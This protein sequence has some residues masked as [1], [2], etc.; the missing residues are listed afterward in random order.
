MEVVSEI[1]DPDNPEA[2]EKLAKAISI[3]TLTRKLNLTKDLVAMG[4]CLSDIAYTNSEVGEMLAKAINIET[5]TRKINR[6]KNLAEAGEC[7]ALI[8]DASFELAE[9]LIPNVTRKIDQ[10]EDLKRVMWCLHCVDRFNSE[11]SEKLIPN[12]AR[13]IDQE[14]D[15]QTVEW[16]FSFAAKWIGSRE[17]LIDEID[18]EVLSRKINSANSR[19]NVFF[20]YFGVLD[21]SINR[22][23]ELYDMITVDE[24]RELFK[25]MLD[26]KRLGK[27]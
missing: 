23:Q 9:K 2:G 11:V 7:I 24:Y 13:R 10:E 16:C 27:L 17:R 25:R 12:I 6:T 1:A 18:L 3:E 4:S 5:L 8:A 20:C 15:L 26:D 21:V 19:R 14:K 22:A